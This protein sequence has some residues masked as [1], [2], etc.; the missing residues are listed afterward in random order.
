MTLLDDIN[1]WYESTPSPPT[2][3]A[4]SAEQVYF[5]YLETMRWGIIFEAVYRR[6]DEYVRIA[7]V[8]PATEGQDWGDHGPPEI[9]QVVPVVEIVETTKYVSV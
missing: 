5:E 6:D 2:G 8:E 1:K 3:P 9:E 4:I 7:D